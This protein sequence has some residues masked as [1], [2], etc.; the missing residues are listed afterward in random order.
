[1]VRVLAVGNTRGYLP[2]SDDF[3][4]VARATDVDGAIRAA[5]RLQPLLAVVACGGGDSFRLRDIAMLHARQPRVRIVGVADHTDEERVLG[6]FRA[7]AR[8]YVVQSS[9]RE[10]L[11][12][13]MGSVATGGTFLDP[14]VADVV[15]RLVIRRG[16][17][18]PGAL[19]AQE[20]RVLE[21]LPRGMT[22]REIAEELG[23]SENTIKTHVSNVLRKLRVKDRVQAAAIA[24][25]QGLV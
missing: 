22:N 5:E 9:P 25:R 1:M 17:K 8:G 21:Y 13:A 15:I 14:A 2:R 19:T 10:V 3:D 12:E 20:R 4:V 23:L 24:V 6:A 16:R 11:R 18:A 7:G